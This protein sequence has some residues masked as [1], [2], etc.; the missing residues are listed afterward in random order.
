MAP[1]VAVAD[2]VVC[3]HVLYNVQDLAPF[4]YALA[5]HAHG[6]VVIEITREHPAAWMSDLWLRFHELRRPSGPTAD[7]AVAA[8]QEL[9]LQVNRED[10]LARPQRGGFRA[11][12]DAVSWIRRLCLPAARDADVAAALGPRLTEHGGLWSAGPLQTHLV[13][14]WWDVA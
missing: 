1:G 10:H 11:R 13:T 4:A 9:D 14:L 7:D 8:L 6:R 5:T 2:V 3:H 12:E